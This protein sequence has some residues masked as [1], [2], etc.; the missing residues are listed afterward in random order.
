MV[1]SDAA[2]PTLVRKEKGC[3]S[4]SSSKD[5][6]LRRARARRKFKAAVTTVV[7]VNKLQIL[8]HDLI[9]HMRDFDLNDGC[10]LDDYFNAKRKFKAAVS[11]IVAINRMQVLG[12]D[13]INKMLLHP[14]LHQ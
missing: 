11:T 14:W 10:S 4:S 3:I 6:K 13:D 8:G 12:R 1:P 7:A 5:N 2:H 9:H